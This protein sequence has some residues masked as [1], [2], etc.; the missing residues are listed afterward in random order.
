MI[1]HIDRD[2]SYDF[3]LVKIHPDSSLY[4]KKRSV[5][6]PDELVARYEKAVH[7][8]GEVQELLKEIHDVQGW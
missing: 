1:I 5:E 6:I 4:Q 2:E 3:Y 8:F 7:E